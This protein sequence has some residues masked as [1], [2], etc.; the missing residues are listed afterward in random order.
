MAA[1][2][3]G[4]SVVSETGALPCASA[5]LPM[6]DTMTGQ[7]PAHPT[8]RI[9]DRIASSPQAFVQQQQGCVGG[10]AAAR[11]GAQ[12][13]FL[14]SFCQVLAGND[15]LWQAVVAIRMEHFEGD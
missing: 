10:T 3:L 6:I 5:G 8:D 13:L 9:V 2:S 1:I 12:P 15:R 7:R 4:H 14:H 11:G